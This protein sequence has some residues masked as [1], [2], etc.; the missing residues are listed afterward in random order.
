MFSIQ[1]SPAHTKKYVNVMGARSKTD[2][3][4][5]RSAATVDSLTNPPKTADDRRPQRRFAAV[6]M[7]IRNEAA[8]RSVEGPPALGPAKDPLAD[9]AV[10]LCF[11]IEGLGLGEVRQILSQ[12]LIK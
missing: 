10:S 3:S 1:N 5:K 7:R 2:G 12:L 9:L 6:T 11:L 8:M 4:L